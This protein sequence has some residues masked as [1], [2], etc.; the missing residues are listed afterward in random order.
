MCG[1]AVEMLLTG[2]MVLMPTIMFIGFYRGLL[3]LR[4]D[5]LVNQLMLHDG[6]QPPENRV[7]AEAMG[8]EQYYEERADR[9]AASPAE[10]APGTVRCR[11]CSAANP[12]HVDFCATCLRRL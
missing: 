10:L 8:L 1:V 9:S 4:D 6:V 7:M 11:H 2:V 12:D 5:D 3:A